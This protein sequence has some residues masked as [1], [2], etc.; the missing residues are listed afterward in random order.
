MNK[1]NQTSLNSFTIPVIILNW[2]GL[3]DTIECLEALNKQTWSNF[4]VFLVDNASKT[5]DLEQLRQIWGNDPRFEF[6]Q[7]SENLGFTLAHNEIFRHH[8]ICN[9]NIKYDSTK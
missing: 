2:N 1:K 9:E 8:I 6:I 5:N 4:K 3:D 7:N